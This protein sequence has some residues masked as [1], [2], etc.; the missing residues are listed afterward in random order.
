MKQAST[1]IER[2][3]MKSM[4]S[5]FRRIVGHGLLGRRRT[6]DQHQVQGG[7]GKPHPSS[8]AFTTFPSFVSRTA[9]PISSS[10]TGAPLSL[11]QKAERK[12]NRFGEKS[13]EASAASRPATFLC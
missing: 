10:S 5:A 11:S 4:E 13:A 3:E 1:K 6:G 2:I 7:E 12:L 8:L 9:S